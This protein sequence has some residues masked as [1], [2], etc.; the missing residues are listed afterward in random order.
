MSKK[1]IHNQI[2]RYLTLSGTPTVNNSPDQQVATFPIGRLVGQGNQQLLVELLWAELYHNYSLTGSGQKIG[3]GVSTQDTVFDVADP[4]G[5]MATSGALGV[6]TQRFYVATSGGAATK[7][8]IIIDWSFGERGKLVATENIY[9]NFDT[10]SAGS[11][12][13]YTII[14]YYR[15]VP[16]TLSEYLALLQSQ[17][18][19]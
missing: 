17:Q 11:A 5:Y 4:A 18:Q 3:M 12:A 1:N 9:V 10:D 6:I 14:I 8:P 2:P 15:I 13:P 16:A 7:V 19:V